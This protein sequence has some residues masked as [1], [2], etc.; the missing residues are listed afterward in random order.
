MSG[1]DALYRFTQYLTPYERDEIKAFKTVYYMNLSANKKA[2]IL[3]NPNSFGPGI[4]HQSNQVS[5]S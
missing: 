5:I 2:Y 1:E 4:I 3:N